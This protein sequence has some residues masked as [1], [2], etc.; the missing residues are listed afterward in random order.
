MTQPTPLTPVWRPPVMPGAT[1]VTA[2]VTT[3]PSAPVD[4][5][6]TTSTSTAPSTPA[7]D[8]TTLPGS[9]QIDPSQVSSF[10][11]AVQQVRADMDAV[12]QQALQ[13]TSASYQPALGTSPT[14]QALT[15][16]FCDR[17]AGDGGL[18]ANLSA[19][20]MHLDQFVS[21]A[22]QTASTYVQTDSSAADSLKTT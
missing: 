3:T 9:W 2:P 13:L 19:V 16:K 8:I 15:A 1:P 10:T 4:T 11:A 5:T 21:N 22:E 12:V 14:G 7:P 17:L 6:T 20:L 18:L